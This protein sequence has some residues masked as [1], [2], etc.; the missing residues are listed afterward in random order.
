MDTPLGQWHFMRDI[1]ALDGKNS[2]L[3]LLGRSGRAFA[4]GLT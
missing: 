2:M 1:A 4:A 3:A